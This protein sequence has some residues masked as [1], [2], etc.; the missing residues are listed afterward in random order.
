MKEIRGK[1]ALITGASGGIGLE[2]ARQLAAAGCN[3]VLSSRSADKLNTLK[4]DLETTHKI[5]ATVITADLSKPGEEERLYTE[6]RKQAFKIDILINNAG[7]GLVGSAIG[8]GCDKTLEMLELNINSLAGLSLRFGKDMAERKNGVILNVGSMV[9]L[10]PVPFFTAYAASK[11]FVKNFSLALRAELRPS[12][13][14]VCCL[15]PGFVR[16]NFD[17]AAGIKN[18]D[19]MKLSDG[20]GSNADFVA[21]VGIA[22]LRRGKAL[23]VAGLLNAVG[24]FF[25]NLIPESWITAGVYANLK[26]KL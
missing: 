11:S 6:I 16:T 23:K 1:T 22:Q 17:A 15:L 2:F 18:E 5:S 25:I 14:E 26:T 13:V 19:Y 21:R 24:A 3:L 8:I 7:S 10:M 9:A 12:R 4:T 20:L